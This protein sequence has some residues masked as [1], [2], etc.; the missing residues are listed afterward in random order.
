LA[1]GVVHDMDSNQSYAQI[2]Q[3]YREDLHLETSA[4]AHFLNDHPEKMLTTKASLAKR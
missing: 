2:S 1:R 4:Q 3:V